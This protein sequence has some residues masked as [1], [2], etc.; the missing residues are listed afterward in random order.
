MKTVEFRLNEKNKYL[1]A[2]NEINAACVGVYVLAEDAAERERA[3][4]EA[5]KAT[6]LMRRTQIAMT[7]PGDHDEPCSHGEEFDSIIQHITAAL[8]QVKERK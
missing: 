6:I 3:L 4:R 2:V 1:Y 7:C 8:A 5:L